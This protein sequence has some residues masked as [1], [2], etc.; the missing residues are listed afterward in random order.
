MIFRDSEVITGYTFGYDPGRSGFFV[1]PT[2][3]ASNN[4]RIFVVRS[5]VREVGLGLKADQILAKNL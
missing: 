4:E 3:E 1:M 2:D 5:A